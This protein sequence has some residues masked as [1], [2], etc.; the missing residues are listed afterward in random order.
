MRVKVPRSS[1][2]PST[3]SLRPLGGNGADELDEQPF[4]RALAAAVVERPSVSEPTTA[5]ARARVATPRHRPR[6]HRR[7]MLASLSDVRDQSHLW[8]GIRASALSGWVVRRSAA[9]VAYPWVRQ[10]R[11]ARARSAQKP[12]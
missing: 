10:R 1:R 12:G 7:A 11:P 4:G 6:L 9:R 3:W 5:A 2:N 8:G